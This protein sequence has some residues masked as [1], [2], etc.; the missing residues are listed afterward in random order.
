MKPI[1][2][3]LFALVI[4]SLAASAGV[5]NAQV[6]LAWNNCITQGNSAVDK[7]YACD[8]T[9]NGAPFKGVLSFISP[10]NLNNFVGMQAVVDIRTAT[11]NQ[12]SDFWRLGVGEC[13][14]GNFSFPG[15][16]TGVG[17]GTTG[18]C[19][20]PWAGANTG[21]GF[22]WYTQ[23]TDDYPTPN[24][25]RIKM[26]F[27]RDSEGALL[28]NQQYIAGAFMLDTFNDVDTGGGVCAGCSDAACIV[29]NQIELYQTVG[30][31]GGDIIVL[32][33]PATRQHITWQGGAIGGN[34]CPIETPTRRT[35]WGAVKSFYR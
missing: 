2:P 22:Q 11:G 5:A 3:T 14:D 33:T 4:A 28:Q 8:G 32:S 30:S 20:N 19:R 18:V 17:T 13:R 16:L 24:G 1:R 9:S 23:T 25:A 26:A 10:A 15:S 6:N 27:A 29:V 12:L 35:T 31:P 7:A 34:G 21:G